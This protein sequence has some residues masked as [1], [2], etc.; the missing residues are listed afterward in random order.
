MTTE[1]SQIFFSCTGGIHSLLL[2]CWWDNDFHAQHQD[3]RLRQK[4][5]PTYWNLQQDTNMPAMP[6][7]R[8][9]CQF[10]I[11][12]V[13]A[14]HAQSNVTMRGEATSRQ[15]QG[16]PASRNSRGQLSHTSRRVMHPRD[17]LSDNLP[18]TSSRHAIQSILTGKP[19]AKLSGNK[20][21]I[22]S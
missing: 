19:F 2:K 14:P 1:H 20:E 6:R 4:M 16:Q 3:P 7:I 9:G 8:K 21:G 17:S 18:S 12:I 10:R 11:R 13:T 22:G 15:P 5:S